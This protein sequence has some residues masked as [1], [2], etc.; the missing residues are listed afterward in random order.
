MSAIPPPMLAADHI[1]QLVRH[2]TTSD[3]ITRFVPVPNVGDTPKWD[4]T[5]E[6]VTVA[7]QSL[8]DQLGHAAS[9]QSKTGAYTSNVPGSRPAARLDAVATLQRIDRQSTKRAAE[10]DL[11]AAR[12]IDR[13]LAISGK[14]GSTQDSEVKSWWVAAR[15]VTGWEQAPYEPDVPCPNVECERRGTLRIRLDDY[16]ATCTN[17]GETWDHENYTQLGDYVRWASEHLRGPRHWLYDAEGYPTECLECIVDRQLMAER[18]IARKRAS[19]P[20]NTQVVA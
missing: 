9:H 5:T 14:I 3:R 13:L 1:R 8:I 10:L 16:L 15:C 20:T 11:P 6:L 17:C 7:H 4:R 19:D 18:I 2:H 12:L